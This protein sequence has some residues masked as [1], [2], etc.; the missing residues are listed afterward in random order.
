V[1]RHSGDP[2][3]IARSDG[4]R[5]GQKQGSKKPERPP[6][7]LQGPFR[8]PKMLERVTRGS[9]AGP[10]GIQMRIGRPC[11][12][13][14]CPIDKTVGCRI[15]ERPRR[16]ARPGLFN[17]AAITSC[18]TS[19]ITSISQRCRRRGARMV[20]PTS[21]AGRRDGCDFRRQP[22]RLVARLAASATMLK[23]PPWA[24]RPIGKRW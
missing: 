10:H 8:D 5:D 12:V 9:V 6:K 22:I 18:R 17:I 3:L 1:S 4:D 15:W 7:R 24:E 19:L 23:S 11:G 16:V 14:I 13:E 21:K 20:A 2:F